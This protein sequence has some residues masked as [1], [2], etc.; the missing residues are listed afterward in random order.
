[1]Q[2]FTQEKWLTLGK[3]GE[4]CGILPCPLPSYM[5]GFKI[6]SLPIMVAAKTSS[7]AATGEGKTG[8]EL[9]KKQQPKG[10]SLND[11]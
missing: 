9:S 2:E 5:V 6:N 8:L 1:M 10:W 4:P 3:N 7:L 11:L